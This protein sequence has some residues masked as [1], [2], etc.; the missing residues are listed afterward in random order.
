MIRE[1]SR[2]SFV[3][4]DPRDSP[5]MTSHFQYGSRDV[6]ECVLF[7]NLTDLDRSERNATRSFS[8]DCID[9][10]LI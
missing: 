10:A 6:N 3:I 2:S 8:P 9:L 1:S 5:H 7:H 4:C